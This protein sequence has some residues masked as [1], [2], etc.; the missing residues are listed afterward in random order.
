[1]ISLMI[2]KKSMQNH[3]KREEGTGQRRG[4]EKRG[5]EGGNDDK[6]NGKEG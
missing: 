2:K 4:E 3:G 5:R 6:E 1:M